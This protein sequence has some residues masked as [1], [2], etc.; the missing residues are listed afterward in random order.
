[1][2]NNVSFLY[3][4]PDFLG[5]TVFIKRGKHQGKMGLVKKVLAKE[6]YAVTAGDFGEDVVEFERQEFIVHRYRKLKMRADR[7]AGRPG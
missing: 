5:Q 6:R 1:M 7:T 3:N 4:N 2:S